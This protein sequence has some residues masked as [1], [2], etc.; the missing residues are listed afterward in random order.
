MPGVIFILK[1]TLL[2]AVI[3]LS[4]LKLCR[5]GIVVSDGWMDGWMDGF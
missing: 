1:A 2:M 5:F 4:V 3:D